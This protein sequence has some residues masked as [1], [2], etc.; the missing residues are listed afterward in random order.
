M[1]KITII[2]LAFAGLSLASCKKDRTCTCTE[3]WTP[4]SGSAQVT[5]TEVTI[6]KVKKG[7]ALDGQCS[8][9]TSQQTAPTQGTKYET[10]CELK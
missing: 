9:G 1:K 3:T 8:S 2:A 5:T 6:K 10:R 7:E 4:V